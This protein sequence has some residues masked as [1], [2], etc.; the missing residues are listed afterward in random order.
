[1]LYIIAGFMI[2]LVGLFSFFDHHSQ[3]NRYYQ[4][5]EEIQSQGNSWLVD[6]EWD[7]ASSNYMSY[8]QL[9]A[10]IGGFYCFGKDVQIRMEEYEFKGVLS[11][12]NIDQLMNRMDKQIKYVLKISTEDDGLKKNN[13]LEIQEV[14]G[15]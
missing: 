3:Y 5:V 9:V 11:E 4:S 2:M 13:I 12:E 8:E 7:D 1:M 10:E 6:E 14:K 15:S